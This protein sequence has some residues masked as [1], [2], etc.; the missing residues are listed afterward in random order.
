MV[1]LLDELVAFFPF[2][3]LEPIREDLSLT[4]GRA[5]LLLV[6][7]PVVGLVDTAGGVLSDHVSRRVLSSA[8]A[9]GYG[10]GFL[11]MAVGPGFAALAVGICLAGVASTVMIDATEVALADLAADEEELRVML[12]HQNVLAAI[13]SIVGPVILSVTLAAGLGWRAAFATAAALLFAYSAFLATQPV[14]PPAPAADGDEP[15]RLWAGLG[16]IL[17]DGRVWVLGLVLL[18]LTPFDEPFL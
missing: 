12:G 6:L 9:A 15:V 2:G 4:Y 10:A 17:R 7:Y 14:P 3:A 13:G 18:L 1:R 5:S 16:Q 8:G 11:I